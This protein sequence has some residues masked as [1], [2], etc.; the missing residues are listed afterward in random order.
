MNRISAQSYL[1]SNLPLIRGL[2]LRSSHRSLGSGWEDF[3][4][5]VLVKLTEDDY[6]RVRLFQGRSSR[7]TYMTVV[8]RRL[9]LDYKDILWGKWRTS[10]WAK[11]RGPTCVMLERLVH[12][13]G[14]R[15]EEAKRFLL[16]DNA[17]VEED[18]LDRWANELGSP[19]RRTFVGETA[20]AGTAS[21]SSADERVVERE[22]ESFAHDLQQEL[23]RC[24]GE[25]PPPDRAI[26]QLKFERQWTGG[27][28]ADEVGMKPAEVYRSLARTYRTLRTALVARGFDAELTRELASW[29][30]LALRVA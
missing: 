16:D 10:A 22:R 15:I 11:S 13:D 14:Y 9:L 21:T 24:I 30:K 28:I 1:E 25:L 5:F 19:R 8:V 23:S 29:D 3:Y 4:S 2:C 7:T 17:D 26:L 20:L 18:V 12:R 27:R 6:R